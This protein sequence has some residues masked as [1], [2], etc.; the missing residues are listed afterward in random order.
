[1]VNNVETLSNL[2]WVLVHG[3]AAFTA[4][5]E[6]RSTG[7][8]LFALAGHVARPGV[9]E[10][11]MVKTTFHDLIFAPVLGGGI[12]GGRQLKAFIP[13]GASAPWFG[14]DQVDLPLGQD[15]VGRGRV[16]A[17]VGLGGGDGRLHLRGARRLADHPV[18]LARVVRPVHAVSRGQRLVGEDPAPDRGRRRDARAIS[19]CSWTSATISLRA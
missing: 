15:E 3:A 14:P 8:R 16:D 11:E 10:V 2:P 1:M 9:Y 18:L 6:G 7:T 17:R 12:P 5:G 4:L 13:G 19:T